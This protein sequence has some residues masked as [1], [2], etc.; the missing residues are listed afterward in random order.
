ME[1]KLLS[2][3]VPI[4]NTEKYLNQ[5][6][7][8]IL[9]QTYQN[10][11]ILLI[12]DG[13]TDGSLTLCRAFEKKDKRIHVIH[14][15]NEGLIA[16]KKVGL[17]KATG[18]Y[19]GFVDSDDWIE[20]DMYTRLM[21]AAE[22]NGADIVVGDNVIEYPDRIVPVTQGIEPGVYTKEELISKVYPQL[23]FT[24]EGKLGFSPSLC[25]KI[26]KRE[27]VKKYQ[28][29]VDER[30][31]AGEDAACTYP[32][33]LEA[34]CIVYV[35]NCYSYHYRIHM[36]SMTHKS[37]KMYIDEKIALLNHLYNCFSR[38]DYDF[39]E[40]QLFMYCVSMLDTYI[41]NCLDNAIGR[42]EMAEYV[43]KIQRE[44]FW[45]IIKNGEI[46]EECNRVYKGTLAFLRKPNEINYLKVRSMH[47]IVLYRQ[48]IRMILSKIK[49]KVL[50]KVQE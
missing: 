49:K 47:S 3:I 1:E 41:K 23:I 18:D 8:S 30:I 7:E 2:V 35:G 36:E 40:R 42:L 15:K 29:I 37:E 20:R 10:L 28:E 17:E 13:S 21:E 11:E 39:L 6:V 14:K 24:E 19:V 4:Y 34:E 45:E 25:T 32:C 26:F 50:N 38:Y 5:C 9:Q 33:M 16:T 12:D 22:T 43:S 27:L 46:Y 48:K 44:K 31:R